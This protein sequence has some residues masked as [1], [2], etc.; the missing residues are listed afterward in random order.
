MIRAI[1]ILLAAWSLLA[2]S[3]PAQPQ[4]AR[5]VGINT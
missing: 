3:A 5:S 4:P 2:A 1:A